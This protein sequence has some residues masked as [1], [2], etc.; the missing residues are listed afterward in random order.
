MLVDGLRKRNPHKLQK[1]L[2]NCRSVKVKRLFL[3]PTGTTI[4]G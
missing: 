2:D 3:L 4:F 1:L